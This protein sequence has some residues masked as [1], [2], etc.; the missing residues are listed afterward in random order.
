MAPPRAGPSAVMS[1]IQQGTTL[2]STPNVAPSSR[3]VPTG[4]LLSQI[5]AGKNLRAVSQVDT[6]PPVASTGDDLANA[7]KNALSEKFKGAQSKTILI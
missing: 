2:K 6:P 7:L 1:Q 3:P 4:D 5:K